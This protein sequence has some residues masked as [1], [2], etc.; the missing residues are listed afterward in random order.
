MNYFSIASN[1]DQKTIDEYDKLNRA[2]PNARVIETF[3]SITR[4]S[5]FQ[6]G[7]AT[8][9]LQEV[10]L[11]DL[12]E[13]VEY[14]RQK[15]IGFNYSFNGTHMQNREFTEEGV[16]EIKK[17]IRDI[18]EAGVRT[19]TIAMPS[20]MRIVQDS[21]YDFSV[22]ASTLCQITNANKAAAFKRRG[23]ERIVLDESINK[24][25]EK[26]RQ[27]REI[28][29]EEVELIV[30]PIC[31]KDCIYR[32]FH[33]NQTTTASVGVSNQ[34][35]INYY[36]H[37]CVLQR[38]E[39]FS[40]LLKISFVRPED[41]KYYNKIG[42][43]RFKI[44]GR[45]TF[46]IGGDP[47]KTVKCYFE[48]RLDGN[49]M[50]LFSMFATENSFQVYV[51]NRKLDDYL[52]PFYEKEG[53]CKSNCDKCGYCEN[54]IKKCIDPDETRKIMDLAKNFYRDYDPYGK[55]IESINPGERVTAT[56]TL[57]NDDKDFMF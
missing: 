29:G 35:S 53:F 36:E 8:S 38:Y 20:I 13:Y 4:G 14:C 45:H 25:F 42:I 55:L 22:K 40:R 37:N 9:Q 17:F 18:Y 47:V 10:D 44:Q 19:I 48:E 12:K 3:G 34:T 21:K 39:N 52:K 54:Y 24:D 7:R 57:L 28:V 16:L 1:F 31:Q 32:S 49:L 26:L 5:Y 51:D 23:I 30:N 11:H 43:S 46:N 15:N 50:D 56:G 33:Y 41:L 2:Y 27:I 6:S